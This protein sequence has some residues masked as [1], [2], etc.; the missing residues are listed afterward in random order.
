MDHPAA[1]GARKDSDVALAEAAVPQAH[2]EA[3]AQR[4]VTIR[5]PRAEV[6]AWF[7]DFRNLPQF[8]ENV[9]S[10]EVLDNGRS[11]WTV[12]APAG[13][14][15]EWTSRITEEEPDRLIAWTSEDDADV[16][17]SGRVE[18]FDAGD[19]GTIVSALI[20]Y[21]PP[22]G[23]VGKLVAKLFQREPAIQ[24][25]RDLRRLKQLLETGEIATAAMNVNHLEEDE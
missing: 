19:R 5:R 1:T 12:K 9:V 22:M 11:H 15:V 17:N 2:G 18:F 25:R 3:I 8:M 21:D 13:Q 6:F 14:T 23:T 24:A 10:I 4:A 16:A 7:R 20:Q